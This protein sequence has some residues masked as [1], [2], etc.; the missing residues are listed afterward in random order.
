MSKDPVPFKELPLGAQII[1]GALF[2]LFMV[3]VVIVGIILG[4]ILL[5]LI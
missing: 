2:V 5:A 4:K 3:I 1:V